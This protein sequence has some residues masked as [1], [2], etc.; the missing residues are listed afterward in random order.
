MRLIYLNNSST[1]ILI[2]MFQTNINKQLDCTKYGLTVKIL[3]IRNCMSKVPLFQQTCKNWFQEAEI[4]LRN[5]WNAAHKSDNKL[6][7][8]VILSHVKKCSFI[9]FI[10]HSQEIPNLAMPCQ[11]IPHNN[12]DNVILF[13]LINVFWVSIKFEQLLF[14]LL[15]IVL[16]M[17]IFW[18]ILVDNINKEY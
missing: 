4:W 13:C 18:V 11:T 3:A 2:C 8:C 16:K 6:H 14:F 9:V 5:Q 12:S 17:E 1:L 10:A 7:W 15:E